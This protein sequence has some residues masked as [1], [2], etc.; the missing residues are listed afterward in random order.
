MTTQAIE[1]GQA[2]S[3]SAGRA[4]PRRLS[5][6]PINPAG[7]TDWRGLWFKLDEKDGEFIGMRTDRPRAD[8]SVDWIF[9]SH[10]TH[11]GLGGFAEIRESGA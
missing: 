1:A 4:G 5:R 8:D 11:D 9:V 6:R 7:Q 3:A 10:L 2:D